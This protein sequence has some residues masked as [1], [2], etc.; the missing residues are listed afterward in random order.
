MQWKDWQETG[1]RMAKKN[2]ST[3]DELDKITKQ[4]KTTMPSPNGPPDPNRPPGGPPI[5]GVNQLLGLLYKT[6]RDSLHLIGA[7][8]A[9]QL[10]SDANMWFGDAPTYLTRAA[11]V[12]TL[13]PEVFSSFPYRGTDLLSRR[14]RIEGMGLLFDQTVKFAMDLI[15]T[16]RVE[17]ADAIRMADSYMSQTDLTMKLPTTPEQQRI[18]LDDVSN[19]PLQIW[20]QRQQKI[21]ETRRGNVRD[22]DYLDSV[23]QQLMN[24]LGLW[25]QG[26][27]GAQP[28]PATPPTTPPPV[29][30][31]AGT[32]TT[33]SKG[34][35]LVQPGVTPPKSTGKKRG[36]PR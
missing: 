12:E 24:A 34:K 25:Q 17:R 28:A 22:Q 2:N 35:T 30:T 23:E 27:P 32:G 8:T 15:Q 11:M 36:Q 6:P 21:Q 29:S 9:K 26:Q 19:G 20:R 14:D 31:P 5:D 16:I 4:R 7:V 10:A 18:R 33:R 1:G 13:C 3:T